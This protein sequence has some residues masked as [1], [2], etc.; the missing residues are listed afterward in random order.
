MVLINVGK[1]AVRGYYIPVGF[2]YLKKSKPSVPGIINR[3]K[4]GYGK[5]YLPT[6]QTRRKRAEKK[7]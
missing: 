1:R 4:Y 7:N 2:V 5:T 6:Q 3:I